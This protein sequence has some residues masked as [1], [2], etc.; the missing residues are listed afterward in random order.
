MKPEVGA[1]I[2]DLDGTLIDSFEDLADAVNM[3]LA[4]HGLP[5]HPA[6]PYK[7]FVGDGMETLVRRAALE[8]TSD[9][10]LASVFARAKANYANNWA[11]KTRPYQGISVMLDHLV[12]LGVP[13]AVLSNKP[14]EFTGDVVEHFFPNT[15]FASVQGSPAGGKAKP[16]PGMAFAV[17]GK[18]GLAP[19]HVAIM[20]DT[21]TDMDTAVGAGM[22][23]VGVLWGFRPEKELLAHGAK[24]I[25]AKPED[26]F[27]RVGLS[28]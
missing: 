3:A 20:G 25:L 18:L 5:V 13:L 21:R 2:F 15:P 9:G 10:A 6:E 16:E 4:E 27:Y 19:D 7:Y 22:L 8:G 28:I 14:H 26:L 24:V 11:V 1:I 23:P 12:A 17:A